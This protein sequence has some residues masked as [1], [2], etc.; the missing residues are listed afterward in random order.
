MFMAGTC[1]GGGMGT[2]DVVKLLVLLTLIIF[3]C[4][5]ILKR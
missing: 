1:L 4:R 5:V 2:A 3:K